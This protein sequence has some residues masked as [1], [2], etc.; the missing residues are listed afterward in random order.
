MDGRVFWFKWIQVYHYLEAL[1][2]GT[3][4]FVVHGYINNKEVCVRALN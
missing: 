1:Y 4:G 3:I 2:V